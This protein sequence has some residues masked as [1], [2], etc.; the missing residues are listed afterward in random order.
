MCFVGA[1]AMAAYWII[2]V[3][4]EIKHEKHYHFNLTGSNNGKEKNNEKENG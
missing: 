1:T 2:S 4:G 3:Y